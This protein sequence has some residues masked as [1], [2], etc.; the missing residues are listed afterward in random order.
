MTVRKGYESQVYYGAAGAAGASLLE[1]AIDTSEELAT[2][3]GETTSRGDGTSPPIKSEVVVCRE[4]KISFN[5]TVRSDDANL[6]ALLA[7]ADSGTPVAIRTKRV[8]GGTGFD[9]DV[10]LSYTDGRPLKGI[11]TLDF[12]CTI[13][14]ELRDPQFNV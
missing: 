4:K 11:Q 2:E 9:G 3:M 7:A 10:N 13:N 6:V 8:A 12:S 1:N 14:D 5:M